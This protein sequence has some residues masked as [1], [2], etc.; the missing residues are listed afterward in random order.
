MDQLRTYLVGVTLALS[1]SGCLGS[2]RGAQEGDAV[3]PEGVGSRPL[4]LPRV[5][6]DGGSIGKNGVAGRCWVDGMPQVGALALR[7]I[8]GEA[9]LG[10]WPA[11][12]PPTVSGV[13][14]SSGATDDRTAS[15]LLKRGPIYAALLAGPPRIVLLPERSE[16]SP[17]KSVETIWVSRPTYDGPVFVRG[18]RLDRAGLVRFGEGRKPDAELELPT[19]DWPTSDFEGR[20]L[21]P[22]WRAFSVQ[23]RIRAPGC[24]AFQVDGDGFSY[25]LTFAAQR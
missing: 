19:G 8:P 11:D 1:L 4:D 18:G 7:G 12:G 21:P 20:R 13:A 15:A 22:G 6:L 17:W 25:L 24:Y 16:A 23:T 10:P 5:D 2:E 9:A 14:R 3:S